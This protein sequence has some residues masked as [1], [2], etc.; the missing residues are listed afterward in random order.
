VAPALH[1][2][3][4]GRAVA[5]TPAATASPAE[6]T[7][8]A[9][10]LPSRPPRGPSRRLMLIAVLAAVAGGLLTLSFS[11]ADHSPR[12]HDIRI[13][14]VAPRPVVARVAAG[15]DHA[16]PGGFTVRGAPSASAATTALR[17]QQIRGALVLSPGTPPHA[18][19]L[20]AGAAGLTLQE[21][22]ETA[23]TD[24]AT[25]AGAKSSVR[26]VVPVPDNSDRSG[27]MSFVFALGLLVPSVIGSV[28]LYLVGR[29]NRVWWRVF[30]AAVF[31]ILVAGFGVLIETQVFGA[32]KT[33]WLAVLGIGVLGALAFVFS[34][35]AAQATL[36]LQATGLMAVTLVFVGNA[37]SGGSVPTGM[38]PDVYRQISPWVPNGAI[39]HGVRSVVYFGGHGLGQP[40][41]TLS[42]WAG[43][44]L[45]VLLVNDLLHL[46]ARRR[47]P[48]RAAEIYAT[49]GVVHAARIG[50]GA[51]AGADPA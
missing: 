47:E 13:A 19:I 16:L 42:L 33:D 30:S 37:I 12:P 20:T 5:D 46:L 27:L 8:P 34:T 38:L 39:V 26:D 44:G 3:S 28:G 50:R 41:L 29:R 6:P 14:V 23:L 45:G 51:R 10:T 49:P 25:A 21:V 11:Y 32:L 1:A 9:A 18:E 43:V 40:L 15:L 24:A 17:D 48:E 22:V 7:P 36:G 35:A 4:A 2:A 31:A